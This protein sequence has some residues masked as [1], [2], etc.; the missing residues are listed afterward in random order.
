MADIGVLFPRQGGI[1]IFRW[2]KPVMAHE[3][4]AW[5]VVS[6]NPEVTQVRVRFV[7]AGDTFFPR[8]KKRL[9]AVTQPLDEASSS[10]V[11]WGIAPAPRSV[12][13]AKYA[14]DGLDRRGEAVV[15]VD[16]EIIIVPPGPGPRGTL[17]Q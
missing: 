8:G 12:R 2:R 14:L 1:V 11:I 10:T 13:R 5:H 7:K 15:S 16:P 4:I 9:T 17:L 3:T 6:E